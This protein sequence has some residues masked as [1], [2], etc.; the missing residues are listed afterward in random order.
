M[1]RWVSAS[2]SFTQIEPDDLAEVRGA[3]STHS[4]M[5]EQ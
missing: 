2:F 5:L 1:Q 3:G 4:T